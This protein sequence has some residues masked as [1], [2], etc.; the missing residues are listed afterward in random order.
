MTDLARL[1]G[2]SPARLRVAFVRRFGQT[3]TAD[4]E[5]CRMEEALTLKIR[6]DASP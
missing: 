6:A 1:I 5:R 3:P 2:V 4:L